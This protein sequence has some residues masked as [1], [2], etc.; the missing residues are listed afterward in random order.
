MTAHFS[1]TSVLTAPSASKAAVVSLM[2]CLLCSFSESADAFCSFLASNCFL[3]AWISSVL[4]LTRPSWAFLSSVSCF[5]RSDS[6]TSKLSLR[7]VSRPS[8]APG[9]SREVCKNSTSLRCALVNKRSCFD[10]AI[11]SCV[12]ALATRRL[13]VCR[14]EDWLVPITPRALSTEVADWVRSFPLISG[15]LSHLL[16]AQ[17]LRRLQGLFVAGHL[18]LSMSDLWSQAGAGGGQ[19]IN[20]SL[21]GFHVVL[22]FFNAL[23]LFISVAFAPTL[24]LLIRVFILFGLLFQIGLHVFQQVHHFGDRPGFCFHG[25]EAMYDCEQTQDVEHLFDRIQPPLAVLQFFLG[26]SRMYWN[27]SPKI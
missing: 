17:G 12:R 18:I 5:L 24:H 20:T 2:S 10:R 4:A 27:L 7:P 15:E 6:C 16:G 23:G 22:R 21:Q 19:L 14:N 11:F 13:E 9:V 25:Q 1:L 8:T 26:K 3:P